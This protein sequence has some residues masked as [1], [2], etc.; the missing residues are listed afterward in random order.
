MKTRPEIYCEKA[1]ECV[2]LAERASEESKGRLLDIAAKWQSM[3]REAERDICIPRQKW[4]GTIYSA[5]SL[6]TLLRSSQ[7]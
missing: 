5:A 1:R 6:R 7:N 2:V 3:A 4:R